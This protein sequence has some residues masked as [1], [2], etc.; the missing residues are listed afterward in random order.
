MKKKIRKKCITAAMALMFSIALFEQGAGASYADDP[1][2]E[3]AGS[4]ETGSEEE[5]TEAGAVKTDILNDENGRISFWKWER[6]NENS[7]NTIFKDGKF[8]ACMFCYSEKAAVGDG[9]AYRWRFVS[10]YNDKDHIYLPRETVN[11]GWY[12]HYNRLV[13]VAGDDYVAMVEKIWGEKFNSDKKPYYYGFDQYANFFFKM[14][15]DGLGG[16]K[17]KGISDWMFDSE[18][19]VIK[20]K[21]FTTGGCMGTLFVKAEEIKNGNITRAQIAIVDGSA[22]SNPAD[23]SYL[24]LGD[25]ASSEHIYIF[26]NKSGGEGEPI[27]QLT[28]SYPFFESKDA[29]RRYY[30]IVQTTSSKDNTLYAIKGNAD[31]LQYLCP[32]NG[33]LTPIHYAYMNGAGQDYTNNFKENI[34]YTYYL[35]A[36]TQYVFASLKGEGGDKDTG[37]GGTTIIDDGQMLIVGDATYKDQNGKTAKADGVVLPE[38][39]TIIVKKGGVLSI[40]G[41][42]INKGTIINEGGTIIVKDGGSVFPYMDSAEGFIEI[43]GGDMIIMPGGKVYTLGPSPKKSN[44]VYVNCKDYLSV[45]NGGNVIN[46]GTLMTSRCAISHGSKIENRKGAVAAFGIYLVDNSEMLNRMSFDIYH[47]GKD[48]KGESVSY[49]KKGIIEAHYAGG[50]GVFLPGKYSYD[51]DSDGKVKYYSDKEKAEKCGTLVVEQGSKWYSSNEDRMLNVIVR[52]Y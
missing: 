49:S 24:D 8:H 17:L 21:F 30:S 25:R 42:F 28:N 19:Q 36:G 5:A 12:T 34:H 13:D 9:V 11:S 20:D 6:V 52:E 26:P 23:M 44:G 38:T 32:V 2:T 51:R 45:I 35:Y 14:D 39:S 29:E 3:S 47:P 40:E 48:G 33:W 1:T 10:L 7:I 15:E 4:E 43:N 41:V 18:S 37:E 31:A 50:R 46:Y 16:D 27:A 22:K